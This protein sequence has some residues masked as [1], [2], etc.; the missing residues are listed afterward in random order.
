M[1]RMIAMK[2]ARYRVIPLVLLALVAGLAVFVAVWLITTS[3]QPSSTIQYFPPTEHNVRGAFLNFFREHG[4]LEVFGY[5][6]TEEFDLEGRRVQYFQKALMELNG[7]GDEARIE[8]RK[9][10]LAMGLGTEPIP[11]SSVPPKDDLTRRYFTE[12][13]HTVGL[14]FLL[15]FDERGG[16]DFFGYPISEET[17]LN[18]R[19]VQYF[20][21]TRM[22]LF[23]D[24]PAGDRVQLGD[25][26]EGHFVFA[27]LDPQLRKG[28]NAIL[29][30]A[31]QPPA[32]PLELHVEAS[33]A[34]V[35]AAAPGQ[36]T[37]FALV[38]DEDDEYVAGARVAFAADYPDGPISYTMDLTGVSGSTSMTF[39]LKYVPVGH[40]L[41]VYVTATLGALTDTTIV[42][43][44]PRR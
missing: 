35:Y 26:G 29:P 22:D 2:I 28:V 15:Y 32:G 31:T 7:S 10:A 39:P 17:Q 11:D 41:M 37:L 34:D 33:L 44:I 16:A 5:P 43:S 4:G 20:E 12:T 38:T 23:P 42:S 8:L 14:P 1:G 9:I 30:L 21:R 6:I 3:R 36:Q 13:Q 19:T 27:G 25:L 18:G 24:R 40:K